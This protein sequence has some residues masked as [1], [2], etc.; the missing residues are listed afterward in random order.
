MKLWILTPMLGSLLLGGNWASANRK[1]LRSTYLQWWAA[2][3]SLR[4][5]A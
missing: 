4:P 3:P 2:L 1:A 5:E